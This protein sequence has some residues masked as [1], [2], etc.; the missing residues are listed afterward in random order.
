MIKDPLKR[1]EWNNAKIKQMT[2]RLYKF[3]ESLN[4]SDNIKWPILLNQLAD[5]TAYVCVDMEKDNA[6]IQANLEA[7]SMKDK[8][9]KFV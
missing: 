4:S 6:D 7:D 8:N 5:L 2:E 9:G 1:M 3:K